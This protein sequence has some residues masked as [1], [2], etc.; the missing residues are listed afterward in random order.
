MSKESDEFCAKLLDICGILESKLKNQE[1]LS[2]IDK[3]KLARANDSIMLADT[4]YSDLIKF[5]NEH[6]DNIKNEKYNLVF[7]YKTE[8][9]LNTVITYIKKA[10]ELCS[11]QEKKI[12]W[13]EIRKLIKKGCNYMDTK[14]QG[15]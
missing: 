15:K 6:Y 2:I 5:G 12:M 3:I 7:T 13:R 9:K 4:Y 11:D 8:G 14:F 10:H 1:L